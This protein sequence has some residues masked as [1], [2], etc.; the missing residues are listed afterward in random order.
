MERS[1]TNLAL[2]TGDAVADAL[3]RATV[4]EA[5]EDAV[6]LLRVRLAASSIPNAYFQGVV[7]EVRSR[8][9]SEVELRPSD[10]LDRICEAFR[11]VMRD[12]DTT[13]ISL[14]HLRHTNERV[15][16]DFAKRDVIGQLR[17]QFID[18]LALPLKPFLETQVQTRQDLQEIDSLR[19]SMERLQQDVAELRK[20]LGG[21]PSA[22]MQSELAYLRKLIDTRFGAV[23]AAE[24]DE[25][26]YE[27][28][29]GSTKIA[30]YQRH[31]PVRAVVDGTPDA[32]RRVEEALGT[33]LSVAGFEIS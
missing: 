18:A 19:K 32:E 30:A 9:L 22:E 14:D 20:R 21:H 12:L 5:F 10:A 28:V 31:I 27:N 17:S 25:A 11:V 1:L 13:P 15:A 7:A 29:G 2:A 23:T 8:L 6:A 26:A 16:E 3:A 4:R 33:L 24:R